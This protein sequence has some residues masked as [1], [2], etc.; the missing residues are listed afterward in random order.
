VRIEHH[1]PAAGFRI[2]AGEGIGHHATDIV[3]DD[4]NVFQMQVF[5][6]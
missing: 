5:P 3:P 6:S 1:H 4:V 2:T